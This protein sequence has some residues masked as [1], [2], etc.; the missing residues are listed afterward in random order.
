MIVYSDLSEIAKEKNAVVTVGSF[1]GFHRGHIKILETVNTIAEEI[2]GSSFMVTFD[3]HPRATLTH[4]SDV[5]ILTSLEEKKVLLEQFGIDNLVVIHFTREF[6]E[7]TS[8]EFIQNFIVG[9][10]HAVQMVI[11]HDHK[12]GKDRLGDENKLREI[13]IKLGIHV[14]VVTAES[15]NHEVISSTKIRNALTIGEIEKA[16]LFLGRNYSISGI[17]VKGAQRGRTLGFP[18]AN[19][20]VDE[21][22]KV[23]PK[24]GVYVVRCFIGDE[25][26]IGVMNLGYRPTFE[27]KHELVPEANILDFDRDIY[28]EKIKVEF[29]QFIR[30]ERKFE[31]RE[32]LI[33]QIEIDK[34]LAS[35]YRN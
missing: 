34:Q 10:L 14:T 29:L 6:S 19:V 15:M 28:G 23:I 8:E 25:S 3:P 31:S 13:G 27:N 4:D 32:A 18:T 22:K 26:H 9:K 30:D 17:V 1:D 11:G 33:H 20:Q 7:Q 24:I 5:R 21:I 16:N 2:G 35:A 12:F